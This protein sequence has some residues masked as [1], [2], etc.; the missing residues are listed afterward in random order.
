MRATGKRKAGSL[1]VQR[2]HHSEMAIWIGNV[3]AGRELRYAPAAQWAGSSTSQLT[4]DA[5]A[6][7]SLPLLQIDSLQIGYCN[8]EHG[9]CL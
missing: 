1:Q 6:L 3:R 2:S 4:L 8:E 9:Q 7:S 5:T